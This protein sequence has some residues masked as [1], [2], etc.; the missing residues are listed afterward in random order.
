MLV[1]TNT[2]HYIHTAG[3]DPA[4]RTQMMFLEVLFHVKI[5]II[6]I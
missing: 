2:D 4:S 3:Q 5:N 1:Q 6:N